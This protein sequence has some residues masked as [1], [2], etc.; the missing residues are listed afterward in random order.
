MKFLKT[1]KSSNI[2][3][4][5]MGRGCFTFIREYHRDS[6]NAIV[7]FIGKIKSLKYHRFSIR[8]KI[9]PTYLT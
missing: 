4:E 2:Y 9:D 1:R 6:P 8:S 7:D 3:K 5:G